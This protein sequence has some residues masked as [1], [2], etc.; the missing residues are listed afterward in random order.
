MGRLEL[1]KKLLPGFIPLF[2]FIVADEIWGTRIGLYVAVGTGIAELTWVGFKEKRF[3]S[4]ILFDTFLLV[5]LGGVSIFLK[6]DIFFKLKP[7]LI[8][9]ILVAILGV[10]A[11]SRLNIIGQMSKRYIKDIQ[12]TDEQ[13]Q[14][15][16]KNLRIMFFIFSAHTVLVFYSAFYMS[17][18][19]W[20]FI[21]G[22]LFY[23]IFGAYF[24]FEFLKL[25]WK[26]HKKVKDEWLPI[27][28]IEGKILGK[29]P[30]KLVHN[31]E[32]I[33]HPVVH[34]HILNNSGSLLLQKR[35]KTKEV[36][37]GKWDSSVGG[38][39]AFGEPLEESLK[40]EAF[41]EIGLENFTARFFNIYKWDTDV[42]SELV[43]IF[44]AN[45]SFNFKVHNNEVDEVRYWSTY[46]IEKNLG[47]N[48]FTPNLEYEYALLKKSGIFKIH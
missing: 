44:L 29:A 34:L 36:Q 13:S 38:H 43:Y 25:R 33:L 10:S 35:P 40:R 19:A 31:G 22:G 11:F 30:R 17:N 8:E 32:K 23:I 39:V 3:D 41:E 9:L 48:I 37:P 45:I 20:A 7:G 15:M 27:V 2:I 24:L 14:L 18:G 42:E 47:K 28:D 5:I 26:G 12:M 1:I 46:E 21:S 6:N 16:L 4:F